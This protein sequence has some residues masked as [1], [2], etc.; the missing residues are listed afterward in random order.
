[1]KQIL[2][3]LSTVFLCSFVQAQETTKSCSGKI[4]AVRETFYYKCKKKGNNYIP[5]QKGNENEY[6][7][8]ENGRMVKAISYLSPGQP[9]RYSQYE[10][11]NHGQMT[12]NLLLDEMSDTLINCRYTYTYDSLNRPTTESC[13]CGGNIELTEHFYTHYTDS[14]VCETFEDKKLKYRTVSDTMGRV[15]RSYSHHDGMNFSMVQYSIYYPNDGL[16]T[17]E[18]NEACNDV[19]SYV[20]NEFG[21]LISSWEWRNGVWTNSMQY[22]Y[23]Y[24][25]HNN[26][27]TRILIDKGRKKETAT[28]VKR[29]I[30]YW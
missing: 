18:K 4:K 10:Y 1:M 6:F 7:Y 24:D 30:T 23:E 17:I 21:D 22:S 19:Y 26:W 13:S 14:I 12:K 8:D 5:L 28:I 3:L 11:D 15:L 20:Y 25:K 9:F 29:E 2:L 16:P 27:I